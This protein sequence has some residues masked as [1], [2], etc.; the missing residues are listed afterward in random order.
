MALKKIIYPIDLSGGRQSNRVE[1]QVVIGVSQYRAFA[2]KN[3]PFY[4][5]NLDV[6]E[7][8]TGRV[9]A[10]GD[11]YECVYFYRD[12]AKLTQGL[13]V[14]GVIVIHN[15]EIGTN[16]TVS[17]NIVGGPFTSSAAAI[18]QAITDLE[19]DNRNVYWRNIIDKPD[20]FQPP[21]H[22]HDIGDIFGFEFIIDI[23][24]AIRDTMIVGDNQQYLQMRKRI[25]ELE[26]V[27]RKKIDDHMQDDADPH[28]VTHVQVN[29]Y[30]REQIDVLLS[31]IAKDL[32][33]LEPRFRSII[34]SIAVVNLRVDGLVQSLNGHGSQLT[35]TNAE[36]SRQTRLIADINTH[37]SDVEVSLEEIR[38]EIA[39][40]KRR[41]EEL[42]EQISNNDRELDQ[43]RTVDAQQDSKI[44]E[45]TEDL[46]QLRNDATEADAGLGIRI[47]AL[48]GATGGYVKHT[49]VNY[50]ETHWNKIVSK[51]PHVAHNGVMEIGKYIDFHD[52]STDIDYSARLYVSGS[53]LYT[54]G[55]LS[56][57]DCYI[58]SDIRYKSCVE[59]IPSEDVHK[60][61]L[62]MKGAHTYITNV[63]GV[64]RVGMI[65]QHVKKAYP[66]ATNKILDE[67]ERFKRLGI[68]ESA[69]ISMLVTGYQHQ[70]DQ[71][72]NLA[73]VVNK[74]KKI[75]RK[76]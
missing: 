32:D 10:R 14:A 35:T 56:V 66:K 25:D 23:L 67:V 37:L 59:K 45:L 42:Q 1:E 50:S 18:D 31:A 55:N 27:L 64:E 72:D 53:Q 47:T 48:E 22:H 71:I 8:N 46:T 62:K 29:A 11:D 36:L 26:T 69:I 51:I 68:S 76:E 57:A 39:L 9:L 54:S 16:L 20:L 34:E 70:Q 33:D 41:D 61:L 38:G 49:D 21:P 15:P 12:I 6:I 2:L 7:T 24:G 43:I 4:P 73:K 28:D 74:L 3:G 63:D 44:S 65:A 5:H 19:I 17:A 52:T 75:V 13:E 30:N 60:A 58:R 40:L